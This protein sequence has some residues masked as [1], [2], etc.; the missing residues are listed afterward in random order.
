[1]TVESIIVSDIPSEYENKAS[2]TLRVEKPKIR[3]IT[4]PKICDDYATTKYLRI[5]LDVLIDLL[6]K[7]ADVTTIAVFCGGKKSPKT[8]IKEMKDITNAYLKKHNIDLRRLKILKCD[9]KDTA[10]YAFYL[11][12]KNA[13]ELDCPPKTK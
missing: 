5:C 1:M 4:P 11:I 10:Y 2:V 13:P 8:Q 3:G 9:G 12:P 7:D 6:Q